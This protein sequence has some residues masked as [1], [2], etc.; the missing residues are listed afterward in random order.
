MKAVE[1]HI[2]DLP[3]HVVGDAHVTSMLALFYLDRIYTLL[4]PLQWNPRMVLVL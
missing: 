2:L 4:H 1:N 3:T